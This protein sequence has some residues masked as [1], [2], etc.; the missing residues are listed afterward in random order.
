MSNA[1]FSTSVY[2]CMTND[3]FAEKNIKTIIHVMKSF[4]N[5]GKCEEIVYLQ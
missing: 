4:N 3:G 2:V 5:I 1:L